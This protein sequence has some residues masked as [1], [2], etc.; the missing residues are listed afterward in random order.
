MVAMMR[1]DKAFYDLKFDHEFQSKN[2]NEFQSFFNQIMMARYPGDFIATY[3]WG[4]DGD[5]KCD[6]Y[7]LSTGTFYQVYAPY[8]MNKSTTTRKMREDFDG[9]L[10]IW[11]DKIKTWVFVHNA[12]RGNPPHV[13]QQLVDF[14]K[15]H[16]QITFLAVGKDEIKSCLF[17]LKDD[18]IRQILGSIPTYEDINNLSMKAIK[19]AVL[20]IQK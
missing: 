3:P 5:Q 6:G 10:E 20:N 11:G 7:R 19:I 16:P 12:I 14:G 8:E 13:V 1:M 2:G 17:E 9:A 4:Q 18:S 15:E